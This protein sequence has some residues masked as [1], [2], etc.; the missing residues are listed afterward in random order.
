MDAQNRLSGAH[1]I[2]SSEWD[3]RFWAFEPCLSVKK[4]EL[5]W[6]KK[7]RLRGRQQQ[8]VSF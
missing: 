7:N 8:A 2:K 1:P 4:L 3:S 6:K 5:R